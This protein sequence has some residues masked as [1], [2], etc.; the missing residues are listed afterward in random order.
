[1]AGRPGFRKLAV[2]RAAEPKVDRGVGGLKMDALGLV[3]GHGGAGRHHESRAAS[4]DGEAAGRGHRIALTSPTTE[5]LWPDMDT[6][7]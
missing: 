1:M 3:Q 4:S 5:D 2:T 7:T 6:A